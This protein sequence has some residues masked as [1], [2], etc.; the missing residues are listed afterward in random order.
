MSI[1]SRCLWFLWSHDWM[2]SVIVK[3]WECAS[4]LVRRRY[5]VVSLRWMRQSWMYWS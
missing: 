3:A 5:V 2:V 4:C 1:L